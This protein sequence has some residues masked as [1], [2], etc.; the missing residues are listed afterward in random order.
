MR[1]WKCWA[2]TASRDCTRRSRWPE[3]RSGA[4]WQ[5][6]LVVVCRWGLW[7]R[8]MTKGSVAGGGGGGVVGVAGGEGEDLV[9]VPAGVVVALDGVVL[10]GGAGD[11]GAGVGGGWVGGGQAVGAE[12]VGGGGDGVVGVVDVGGGAVA[13]AVPGGGWAVAGVELHGA[14][15]AAVGVD[16]A[17][18]A[19]GG[20]AAVVGFD[21]ADAGQQLPGQLRAGARG[22]DVQ[23]QV[24]PRNIPKRIGAGIAHSLGLRHLLGALRRPGGRTG[25]TQSVLDG[26]TDRVAHLGQ[27]E[28]RGGAVGQHGEQQ[29]G[30]DDASGLQPDT[31]GHGTFHPLPSRRTVTKAVGISEEVTSAMTR[32]RVTALL[33]RCRCRAVTRSV[34][35]RRCRAYHTRAASSG[36]AAPAAK[37]VAARPACAEASAAGAGLAAEAGAARSARTDGL[38]VP[39]AWS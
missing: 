32:T 8:A 10:G 5:P 24:L 34:G 2:R 11:G 23:R 28:A 33:T 26:A 6:W 21:L 20:G 35:T 27:G 30:P 17:V 16:A 18:D 39:S 4:G 15:A 9:D 1:S 7:A 13:V 36:R 22:A 3:A 29:Q 25:R 37:G 19:G 38:A 31:W 14:G 12:F